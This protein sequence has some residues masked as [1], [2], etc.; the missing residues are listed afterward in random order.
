MKKILP[1]LLLILVTN[2]LFAFDFTN[3]FKDDG[4]NRFFK[5]DSSRFDTEEILLDYFDNTL[6]FKNNENSRLNIN[7]GAIKNFS[8]FIKNYQEEMLFESTQL[9]VKKLYPNPASSVAMVDYNIFK[10]EIKAKITVSNLLGKVVGEYDLLKSNRTIR[11]PTVEYD[12]GIY[13]YTLSI[14]GKAVRSK[15]LVVKHN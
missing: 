14:N 12:A 13:F 8:S 7:T 10:N 9:A 3:R 11:I 6:F 1:V 4:K 15:K 2:C 5:S